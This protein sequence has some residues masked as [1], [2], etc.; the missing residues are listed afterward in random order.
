MRMLLVLNL[1]I[2]SEHLMP[3][4]DREMMEHWDDSHLMPADIII[5]KTNP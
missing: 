1:E 5:E 3:N 4:A 2:Y